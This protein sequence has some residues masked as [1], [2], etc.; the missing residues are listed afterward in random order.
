MHSDCVPDNVPDLGLHG[1]AWSTSRL[2]Y[3]KKSGDVADVACATT[4][5]TTDS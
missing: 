5:A 2:A 3:S 1:M 4:S